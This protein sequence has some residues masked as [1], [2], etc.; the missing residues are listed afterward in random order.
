LVAPLLPGDPRQL[1]TFYLDGRLGSGGQGVVY[2][3]YGADNERVAVK[4]LHGV[5]DRDR[6]MLRKEVRVWRQVAPFC[7]A[8]VLHEDLDGPVPFV[9]SEYVLG[10]DLWRTVDRDGPYGPEELR[11]LAIGV[12]TALVAI[13]QAGVVHRDL[14]PENI[15]LG[16]DGP[17]VIDFGI[18]RV[19][20]PP[21]TTV[22]VVKG[23]LRYMPPE[24]YRGRR[25]DTKVDVWGWGAVILF[26]ATGRH[27]FDGETVPAIQYQVANH[28]PETSV[29][30]EP[31]R[32]LVSASLSKDPSE[33][34]SSE[35]LLL[36]L[37]GR[38][39][40]AEVVKEAV[41]ENPPG[42]VQP[43]RAELAEAVF[44]RFGTRV[45]EAV[46]RMFL[47]L[48]APGE[49][50]EDT[51][52]SARRTEFADGQ[53]DEQAVEQV[54]R[55][56]T[57]AGI[58]VWEDEVVTLCSA[59]LIR[60]WPRLR[61]WVE[62]ERDGLGVHQGLCGASRLWDDHG[63]KKSDLYQGTA[64]ERA[65]AWAATGRRHL[66]LN[67]VERAFL[68]A[69]AAL[70]RRR[71]RL[72]ALL[73]AVLAVLLVIAI[74]AAA[75]AFDQRQTVIGQRDRATS[76]QVAGM[77]Q[78]IRRANP[79]LARRLAVAAA[80][81]GHNPDSLAALLSLR[82]QQEWDTI[83]LSDFE[84]TYADL[85]STG[86]TL[87]AT[88]GTRVEFWNVETRKRLGTYRPPAKVGH[89]S[90]SG[91]GR[92]AAVSTEDG[93][94]RLV[95]S[96]TARPRDARTYPSRRPEGGPWATLSPRGT[97]LLVDRLD[98]DHGGAKA[99]VWDTRTARKIITMSGTEFPLLNTTFTADERIMSLPGENGRPF[100]WLD[101]EK[102]KRITVPDFGS[103]P[104]GPV[105]FSPDGRFAAVKA[106]G[107]KIRLYDR[108]H[109]YL[110]ATELGGGDKD[111]F[112]PLRFSHDGRFIARGAEI[113]ETTGMRTGPLM[114][115][116]T[117]ESECTADI[118]FPFTVDG[119]EMR[120][121]GKDGLVRTLDVT[122][123]TKAAAPVD[124]AYY[125][126]GVVSHDRSTIAVRGSSDEVGIWSTSV[127]T[128]QSIITPG[129][130]STPGSTSN[131][132]SPGSLAPTPGG[133]PGAVLPI[134]R[135]VDRIELSPDGRL[136]GVLAL[137]TGGNEATGRAE[138]EI[139]DVAKKTRLGS[140]RTPLS[141]NLRSQAL[142]E[143]AFSPDGKS[144]AVQVK[145]V[146]G[147]N[148][149]AFWDLTTMRRI[150]EIRA[151]LGYSGIGSSLV[152]LPDGKSLVAAPHFGRVEFPSGRILAKAPAGF[153][154][155]AI[156]DDGRTLYSLPR[157]AWPRIRFWD[158]RTLRLAG[159]DLR[160]G[161]VP[162][163]TSQLTAASPDGRQF[164]SV[165][166][167]TT[168]Y[169]IKLWDR[170]AQKQL[171]I[172]LAAPMEE[173]V[174]ITYTTDGSTV[175]SVDK[176]GRVFTHAVA[177]ERLI[178]DLCAESGP[179][180]EREWKS[181]IPDVPYRKTC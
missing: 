41:P 12:A 56:F 140:V 90:L 123:F 178:R 112:F 102:K 24:R 65:L 175:V 91:D 59:A 94:T 138:I 154:V 75:V 83:K 44:A 18:A 120:C 74:G 45:Q 135:T 48:V 36:G 114:R 149:L 64:L 47:R 19:D 68:D 71:G 52:R 95:D 167:T 3:G 77:A 86:R 76:V 60:A 104:D 122:A 106:K 99:E 131:P 51:L 72:R 66:A 88:D 14:K 148:T 179:L 26:A 145:T 21:V 139:W 29:L 81:L 143:F 37:V 30:D 111:S 129:P 146:D 171:G 109:G 162:F 113:W 115:Y 38:A 174:A 78:S 42:P 169:Q 125:H 62:D 170:Q 1:G 152:F 69:A 141:W 28:E 156:S 158:A 164:A 118:P 107:G 50:A 84:P 163:W 127:R 34:P 49:R 119:S 8:K 101:M 46:P 100:T 150:R 4:A 153:Q 43:S 137:I 5:S 93:Y 70:I 126:E 85:D 97:Y 144:L 22:G 110:T 39:D 159:E 54:L 67:L 15:L 108:E 117:T 61:E 6:D 10:S 160:T 32:S 7:T 9:V 161:P 98:F 63:H 25:G 58:L 165:H 181:H 133:A 177:P 157:G 168:G 27:A 89:L 11:R 73:S 35:E 172:A 176:K 180:T 55:D 2:E 134:A 79:D 80:R 173:I 20:E 33:R 166:Q 17:R 151:N 92:T 155:D 96:S 105:V 13:H 147:N 57:D 40:L 23:S 124:G 53:T 130:S 132:A 121:V 31:L 87:T 103:G 16:P 142:K 116:S 136:L 128:V 82:Y